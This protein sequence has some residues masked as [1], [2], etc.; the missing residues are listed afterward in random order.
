MV[1]NPNLSYSDIFGRHI[2][3]KSVLFFIIVFSIYLKIK[4]GFKTFNNIL[5]LKMINYIFN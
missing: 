2:F 4:I 3:I 1:E 5:K